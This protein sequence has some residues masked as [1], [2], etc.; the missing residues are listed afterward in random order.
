M[1][2]CRYEDQ[3]CRTPNA[4][5]MM[6]RCSLPLTQARKCSCATGKFDR[7]DLCTECNGAK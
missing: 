2:T 6:E 4:C 1:T 7:Y 3:R 5:K